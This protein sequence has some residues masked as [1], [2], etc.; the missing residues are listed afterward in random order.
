MRG[1][2][3]P[4]GRANNHNDGTERRQSVPEAVQHQ[5]RHSA[6]RKNQDRRLHPGHQSRNRRAEA[7]PLRNHGQPRNP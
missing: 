5:V 6:F 4:A 7:E 2:T 3:K 1:G